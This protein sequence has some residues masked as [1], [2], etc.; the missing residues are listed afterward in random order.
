MA[1]VSLGKKPGEWEEGESPKGRGVA[2]PWKMQGRTDYKGWT[3]PSHSTP[4]PGLTD[5]GP[6]ALVEALAALKALSVVRLHHLAV[7]SPVDNPGG[8]QKGPQS[9]CCRAPS[10]SAALWEAW[11]TVQHSGQGERRTPHPLSAWWPAASSKL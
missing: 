8:T 9:P 5:T 11:G 10:P 7:D 3:K 2:L 6:T 1:A 4:H